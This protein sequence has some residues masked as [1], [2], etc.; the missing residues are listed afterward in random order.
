M[1]LTPCTQYI[2]LH[3]TLAACAQ[4]FE[5]YFFF[6]KKNFDLSDSLFCHTKAQQ[7]FQSVQYSRALFYYFPILLVLSLLFI[8]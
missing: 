7:D 8:I 1:D 3:D 4:V 2:G 6:L 5:I